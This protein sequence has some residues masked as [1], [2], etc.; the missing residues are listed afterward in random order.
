MIRVP[1]PK[2]RRPSDPLEGAARQIRQLHSR[3]NYK[4]LLFIAEHG[5]GSPLNISKK[6]GLKYP[7]VR[8][9]LMRMRRA[10]IVQARWEQVN[11]MRRAYTL[12]PTSPLAMVVM[13]MHQEH[14]KKVA[15]RAFIKAKQKEE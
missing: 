6:L 4:I 8:Q 12:V 3:I 2:K 9:S 13:A 11:S 1:L 7:M 10:G 5:I 15:A 14:I